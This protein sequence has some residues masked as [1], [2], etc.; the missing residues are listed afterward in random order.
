MLLYARDEN[1]NIKNAVYSYQS[2]PTA[3]P[4]PII[5]INLD[6][7]GEEFSSFASVSRMN[8]TSQR[9]MMVTRDRQLQKCVINFRNSN[10]F[11]SSFSLNLIDSSRG[12]MV[13]T[14]DYIDACMF[15]ILHRLIQL[16]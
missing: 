6:S 11:V 10:K 13:S 15:S 14:Y 5:E 4:S 2:N 12:Q 3:N 7:T 8:V 9:T 1:N 16:Q